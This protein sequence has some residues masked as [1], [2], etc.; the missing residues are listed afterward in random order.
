MV[1][2]A[3]CLKFTANSNSSNIFS[4]F[5]F[6][7]SLFCW[8]CYDWN[9]TTIRHKEQLQFD[10][11]SYCWSFLFMLLFLHKNFVVVCRFAWVFVQIVG[12]KTAIKTNFKFMAARI[13]WI[14]VRKMIL[15]QDTHCKCVIACAAVASCWIFYSAY[16]ERT[17]QFST[18]LLCF[19]CNF[20]LFVCF[21]LTFFYLANSTHA[22]NILQENFILFY[23]VIYATMMMYVQYDE[24]MVCKWRHTNRTKWLCVKR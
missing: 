16:V 19:V 11:E 5:R 12:W 8:W 18:N 3:K 20:F 14:F 23:Q 17:E 2:C 10:L 15:K 24:K 7:F 6:L 9:S 13:K 21:S 4:F 22:I 1:Q